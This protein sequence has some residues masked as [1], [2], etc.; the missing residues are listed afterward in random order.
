MAQLDEYRSV[1]GPG[2]THDR[3][4]RLLIVDI[5]RA[6]REVL[7]ASAVHHLAGSPDVTCHVSRS[8]VRSQTGS[9]ETCLGREELIGSAVISTSFLLV[10][11]YAVMFTGLRSRHSYPAAWWHE[12]DR[13]DWVLPGLAVRNAAPLPTDL[14]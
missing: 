12:R 9:A 13:G 1:L 7:G 3:Q 2:R 8:L 11:R 6:N 4:Q 5:E 10:V 14:A